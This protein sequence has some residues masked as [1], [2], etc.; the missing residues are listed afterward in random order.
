MIAAGG[1]IIIVKLAPVVVFICCIVWL[2]QS[3]LQWCEERDKRLAWKT[4][5]EKEADKKFWSVVFNVSIAIVGLAVTVLVGSVYS[6]A[7]QENAQKEIQLEEMALKQQ[8][9]A[10]AEEAW[11]KQDNAARKAEAERSKAEAERS[12]ADSERRE[13]EAVELAEQAR[14]K[15]VEQAQHDPAAIRLFE[16]RLKRATEGEAVFQYDLAL[17]YLS[18]RGIAKDVS[19]AR[20]WLQKAAAQGHKKAQSQLA[21]LAAD[22]NPPLR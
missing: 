13:K 4:R 16:L 5:Q 11:R 9:E 12:K 6:S 18:G 14:L 17:Q 10:L 7:R 21:E 2:L 3:L 8:Q 20:V 1:P 19:A 22:E 15:A